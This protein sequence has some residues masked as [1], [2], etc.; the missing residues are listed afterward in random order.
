MLATLRCGSIV[1]RVDRDLPRDA[2][3]LKRRSKQKPPRRRMRPE[4]CLDQIVRHSVNERR[5]ELFRLW[6]AWANVKRANPSERKSHKLALSHA[7]G[8][9]KGLFRRDDHLGDV[10]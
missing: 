9:L 7:F 3:Q 8:R 1:N 2:A 6:P 5:L 10:D 4:G